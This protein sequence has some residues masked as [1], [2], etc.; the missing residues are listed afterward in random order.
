MLAI[1]M[2]I[3]PG[4][5]P[6]GFWLHDGVATTLLKARMP[7]LTSPSPGGGGVL[8]GG[9]AA[10]RA[11]GPPALDADGPNTWCT[12]TR[13]LDSFEATVGNAERSLACSRAIV[14]RF[15]LDRTFETFRDA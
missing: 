14:C 1:W 8:R 7:A 6:H 4:R 2:G 9:G 11:T 12:K 13:W 3:S 15:A 10:A 5:R